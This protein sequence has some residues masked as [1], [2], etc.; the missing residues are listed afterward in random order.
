MCSGGSGDVELERSWSPRATTH[1]GE[2]VPAGCVQ[3]VTPPPPSKVVLTET[4]N[5]KYQPQGLSRIQRLRDHRSEL[6]TCV[7]GA[8]ML[9]WLSPGPDLQSRQIVRR[10][11]SAVTSRRPDR[12]SM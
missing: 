7:E 1:A 2:Y 9:L 4:R 11:F 6:P 8:A 10:P 12:E 5:P 3:R